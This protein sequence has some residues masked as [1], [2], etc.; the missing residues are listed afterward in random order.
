MKK[1][2]SSLPDATSGLVTRFDKESASQETAKIGARIRLARE[3][4]GLSQSEL[5]ERV[6]GSRRGIQ[7]NEAGISAP[8]S[9]LLVGLRRLGVNINWL[10]N[11]S[12]PM[13]DS[14][15]DVALRYALSDAPNPDKALEAM[16]RL[17]DATDLLQRL[18][19][20]V[21]YDP[22][23]PWGPMLVELLVGEQITELGAR[24]ILEHLKSTLKGE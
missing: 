1:S 23:E 10:L 11:E 3:K 9:A 14:R 19:N 4:I 24:R 16:R 7:N 13:F 6:G 5:A 21:G 2:K 20:E 18:K 12:G 15:S 17:R 22:P 8:N